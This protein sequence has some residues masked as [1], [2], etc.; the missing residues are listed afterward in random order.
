MVLFF[1]KLPALTF[2]NS[3]PREGQAYSC[4]PN[5]I[6]NI[7][8]TSSRWFLR[9]SS[10]CFVTLTSYSV[11]SSH[12][13]HSHSVLSLWCLSFGVGVRR[14]KEG[15]QFTVMKATACYLSSALLQEGTS[16]LGG[17]FFGGDGKS[18]VVL[19]VMSA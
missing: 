14:R 5:L 2:H 13:P 16:S 10:I 6:H 19:V 9:L 11:Q 7:I 8:V 3:F 1:P 4:L 17:N 18:R 12:L 15:K